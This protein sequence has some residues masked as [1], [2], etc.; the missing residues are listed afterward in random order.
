MSASFK[1][2]L[3]LTSVILAIGSSL[4]VYRH[5]ELETLRA[6]HRGLSTQAG[7]IGITRESSVGLRIPKRSREN[8]EHKSRLKAS[9]VIS[10][11]KEMDTRR[12]QGTLAD[13]AFQERMLGMN[14]RL[15]ELSA[16]ELQAVIRELL[17]ENG[18]TQETRVN[19]IGSSILLLSNDFPAEAMALFTE[20]GDALA[21]LPLGR[22]VIS[23]VLSRWAELDPLAAFAWIRD[24]ADAHPGIS[25]DE[26]QRLILVGTVKKS[27]T[28][29]IQ[30][31]GEMGVKDSVAALRAIVETAETPE[32]RSALLAA[33]REQKDSSRRTNL[34]QKSLETM[35][36]GL[37]GDSF[38]SVQSWLQSS[39][40]SSVEIAQFAAGLSYASTQQDT[41]RWIDW[42]AENLPSTQLRENVDSLI[43]QW[44]QQDYIAAGKWLT[45]TP[46][47]PAKN[48]AISTYAGTVAEYEPQ[49][50]VQWA[51]TLPAGAER[52]A[53]LQTILRNWPKRD[54]AA[55]ASFAQEYG[56]R[57]EP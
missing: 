17:R 26:A 25:N 11:A 54:A 2:S 50:A 4:G 47:G 45:A 51:L 35:A 3:V 44:T 8:I 53:T 24:H 12:I 22:H 43:G 19:F 23:K 18:L 38:D 27:P 46:A 13:E 49:T 14:H 5:R 28:L 37:D 34:L 56:L 32:Q 6:E 42:M 7:L 40:L 41:G 33:L 57:V 1:R 36:R 15:M 10:F 31:L 55:A 16:K 20:S 29:A 39:K 52:Q 30:L 9:E 21:G 48:A